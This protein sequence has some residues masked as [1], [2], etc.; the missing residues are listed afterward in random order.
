MKKL[1]LTI[2]SSL[3]CVLS[4]AQTEHLTFKGLPIDGSKQEFVKELQSQ[5]YNVPKMG[6]DDIL[7]GT[8][9]GQDSYVFIYDTPITNTVWKVGVLFKSTYDNWSTIKRV[10]DDLVDVYTK[11]MV[12]LSLIRKSLS[13]LGE[14]VMDMSYM[15]CGLI[16]VFIERRLYVR[17]M[18]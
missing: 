3:F 4:Y 7:S 11:N 16:G 12:L 17:K 5:G 14:R 15:P 8:F 13:R 9:I 1:L 10:Y 18:G 2:C 6:D